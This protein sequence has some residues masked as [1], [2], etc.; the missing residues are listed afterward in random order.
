[1]KFVEVLC[2]LDN[3]CTGAAVDSAHLFCGCLPLYHMMIL[4]MIATIVFVIVTCSSSSSTTSNV[5]I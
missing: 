2:K 4:L 3:D 5:L 1:M